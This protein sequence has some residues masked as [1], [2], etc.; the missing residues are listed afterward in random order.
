MD[1][2]DQG[3]RSLRFFYI[4][5]VPPKTTHHV[6]TSSGKTAESGTGFWP[7]TSL[8]NIEHSGVSLDLWTTCGAQSK[9]DNF[10]NAKPIWTIDHQKRLGVIQ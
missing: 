4:H 5:V 6:A 9:G 7:R 10:E 8:W 2:K 3:C 1:W